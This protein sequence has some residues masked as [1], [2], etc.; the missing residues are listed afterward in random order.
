MLGFGAIGETAIGALPDHVMVGARKATLSVSSLIIPEK[1]DAEGI[2]IK[3]T[4]FVWD[5]MVRALGE[6][7]SIAYSLPPKSWRRSSPVR[8]SARAMT[9]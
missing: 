4:S 3:S 7:W 8:L 5:E 9:R 6:D 1:T 2:L